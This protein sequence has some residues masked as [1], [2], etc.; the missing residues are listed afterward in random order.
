MGRPNADS[1]G[2]IA[3]NGGLGIDPPYHGRATSEFFLLGDDADDF[4]FD[5][6]DVG[7]TEV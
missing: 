5:R 3:R 1:S 2:L 4:D 7:Y 6:T